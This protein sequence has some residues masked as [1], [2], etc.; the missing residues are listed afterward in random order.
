MSFIFKL[1]LVSFTVAAQ[2]GCGDDGP[3]GLWEEAERANAEQN[4]DQAIESYSAFVRKFPGHEKV[5][6]AL[7]NWAAITQQKGDMQGAINLYERLLNEYPQ[8]EFGDEA[9]FMIAF[10]YEEYL[11]DMEK[12]RGAYQRVIDRYPNSELAASAKQL[13]P[14]VG[15]SPEEWVRFQDGSN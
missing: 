6:A 13:L 7:K 11:N 14:H 15:K 12:A 1:F 4:M 2:S 9:Q 10:I 3:S 5:P 8:S